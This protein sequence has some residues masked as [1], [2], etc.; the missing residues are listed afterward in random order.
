MQCSRCA[1][2]NPKAAHYCSNCGAALSRTARETELRRQ[3]AAA[4]E[5]VRRLR[6][7]IPAAI[8]DGILHDQERLHGERREVTVLFAD[9]VGF[10]HL[11]ASLDAEPLFEL[12]NDLLGHLINCIHRYAGVVDRL[13]GDGLIAVFGAP[14]A[15]ENDAE[16]AVRAA[17]DM[18]KAAAAFAPIARAQLGAPLKIRIGIDS[19]PVVAGIIGTA[20]Q[21]T[22]TVI[23]ESVNL[24]ARLE[25]LARPSYILVSSRVYE[26]TRAL[27]NFRE[28]SNV[29]IKG[30]D[31]PIN[32]YETQGGR[33]KP[34]PTRGGVSATDVLIGR[35]AELRQL[36]HMFAS[37]YAERRGRLVLVEGEAGM[38]KSRLVAEALAASRPEHAVVWQGR[39]LP[40]AQGVGYGIFRSLL[41]E[42]LR[43]QPLDGGWDAPVSPGLRPLLGRVLGQGLSP[44]ERSTP[45]TL[46]PER[47]KQLTARATREWLL[48]A[49]RERPVTL[50]LEDFHWADD[51][52]RDLLGALAN[53]KDEAPIFLC[54]ITR[55]QRA[56]VYPG[57]Q[58][59][60]APLD[61]TADLHLT[62]APLS[63][64]HSRSLL[65]HLIDLD[66]V[67]DE[68][69]DT[70]LTRAEGNP[71]YIEEFVRMLIEKQ[72]LAPADGKWKVASDVALHSL[73]I[74]TTL[75]RLMLARVD[76]LP[77]DLQNVVRTAAVIGLQFS[78]RLLD[79]VERR[80]H[81]SGGVLPV[82]ER[83]TEVGWLVK[84]PEAGQHTYAFRSILS[85][86]TVYNS[87]L[88]SQRPG[89]HHT[90][91]ECIES[92]YQDE[93]YQQAEVLA[94]HY[95]RA[96][97]RDKAMFY[98]LRAADRARERFATR[99]AIEYYSRALQFSQHL[100]DCQAE[101]WRAVVGLGEIHQLIGEYEDASAF[102]QAA[103]ADWDE[104]LPEAR[105]GV[106]LR[107]GQ[108]WDKR[109]APEQAERAL[110]EALDLLGPSQPEGAPDDLRAQICAELGWF[111]LRQGDLSVA[112]EQLERSLEL[113]SQSQDFEMLASILSRLGM[114]YHRRSQWDR[115]TAS[116]ERALQL[117]QQL[118]DLVGVASTLVN[119][120]T[121][122]EASGDWET[123]LDCFQ[124]AA[125]TYERI[126][127]AEGLAEVCIKLGMLY[128]E[129]GAWDQAEAYL[130][131]SVAIAQRI[132]QPHKL[133]LAHMNL[134]RLYLLQGDWERSAQHLNR[135]IPLYQDVG[136]PASLNLSR[137]YILYGNLDLEQAQLVAAQTWAARSQKL[138][139]QVNGQAGQ[140]EEWGLYWQLLGRIA[141]AQGDVHTALRHLERSRTILRAVGSPLEVG[142][143]AYWSGLLYRELSQPGQARQALASAREVFEGLG[144]AVYLERVD[145]A[146]ARAPEYG[147]I[148]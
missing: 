145:A 93:L 88:H 51:L 59:A 19:G 53:L 55:P 1:A 81:G 96:R 143:S 115:A 114:L 39:A 84:R 101:R 14:V 2:T 32:V 124:R 68:L 76:R 86:E 126:D 5:E 82:L 120:A 110:Q 94:L 147:T 23:G 9:M 12:I 138:L 52:S 75:R 103:L 66:S 56:T 57:P 95:E 129:R 119:L 130:S 31:A 10:T 116:V 79:E 48:A 148:D 109:G 72:L 64:Q 3:L 92:L 106:K 38:G 27:F 99:E 35:D 91:A 105:A 77:E 127:E 21:A 100:S 50:I 90:V 33:S 4:Q 136:A 122:R 26:Q 135:S 102:F 40:Y 104:A 118:G 69:V 37:F 131:R 42:A 11:S 139:Q 123:A 73:E 108:V 60:G 30:I 44:Q 112:Q 65:G 61:L 71:L 22:Y 62:L 49:S 113:A 141:G 121:V 28:I 34:M 58:L 18:Q 133:G 41:Q 17:L 67:P 80:I 125:E 87:L 29:Q 98:A 144:A 97:V 137:A 78:A 117:R 111:Y 43:D 70:I 6:R 8:A 74:P 89:L 63:A 85:Q 132:A 142:R 128:A 46:E 47:A 13:T 54:V 140:P 83:L 20:Q 36:S 16:L 15:Y 45:G 24:A 146:L 107:L 134:G 25:A 7:H